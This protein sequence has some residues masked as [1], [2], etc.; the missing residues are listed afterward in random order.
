M[1]DLGTA[2]IANIWG[3]TPEEYGELAERLAGSGV[4]AIELNLSCPNVPGLGLLGGSAEGTARAVR[5]ARTACGEPLWVKLP[6][7]GDV[8]GAARAAEKEGAE[9]ISAANTFRGLAIDVATGRPVFKRTFGGLSGPAIK[10]LALR[11]VYELSRAVSIP[12]IGIGGI[13]SWKDALEFIMAGA[14]AVQVGTASFID[15]LCAPRIIQGLE[16][17]LVERGMKG[18]GEIRGCAH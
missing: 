14:H 12:V 3:E 13:A 9:A 10:P 15:P 4:D 1:R 2:V 17:F 5:A 18:W 16:D 6:P 8:L 7:E 11:W